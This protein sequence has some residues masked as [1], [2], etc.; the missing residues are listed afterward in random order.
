MIQIYKIYDNGGKTFDRYTVLTE[1][2]HFGKS[3]E[4]LGLSD[5]PTDP[6]GFSQWGDAYEGD[7]LGKEIKFEKL[8]E[9][10]QEHI[11][12]RLHE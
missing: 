6:Q 12:E 4:A 9:N 3:C 5:N 10:I 7:H 1:P 11:I 2:Y 8:P